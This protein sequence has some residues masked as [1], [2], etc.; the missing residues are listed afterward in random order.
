[1][2]GSWRVSA[3][4]CAKTRS[5]R[6][7]LAPKAGRSSSERPP[8]GLRSTFG[9]ESGPLSGRPAVISLRPYDPCQRAA[10]V[11]R[12]AQPLDDAREI[13]ART[14][15]KLGAR[16]RVV[17]DAVDALEHRP[18]ASRVFGGVGGHVP[19]HDGRRIAT[20]FGKIGPHERRRRA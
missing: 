16:L 15:A 7:V 19:F 6:A 9:R 4:S 1:M 12:R 11:A 8:Q 13:V 17:V 2:W 10:H 14:P 20:E 18:A 3:P 5:P